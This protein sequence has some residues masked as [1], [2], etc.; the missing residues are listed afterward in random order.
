[1]SKKKNDKKVQKSKVPKPHK[2]K[3]VPDEPK[4]NV[5]SMS[6]A[7]RLDEGYH[8]FQDLPIMVFIGIIFAIVRMKT[9]TSPLQGFYWTN[10]K[11]A[12]SDFFSYYKAAFIILMATLAVL[13]LLYRLM[14]QSLII[15][16]TKL[17]IPMAIYIGFVVLSWIFSDYGHFAFKGYNDRFEGSI[18]IISYFIMMFYIINTVYTEKSVKRILTVLGVMT[19]IIGLLG[20]SQF[21]DMDFFRTSFGKKMITPR[22]YWPHV[23][24]LK[25][26]FKNREIYQTVYN[27]NYVSFYLAMIIPVFSMLFFYVKEMKY[28]IA[29]GVLNA[30]LII[31]LIGSKSSGG[32]L[33]IGVAFIVG[34]VLLNKRLL[35]W[36]KSVAV[37]LGVAIIMIAMTANVLLPELFGTVKRATAP[38]QAPSV[39]RTF[40]DYMDTYENKLDVSLNGQAVTFES[41][42]SMAVPSI[43]IY[44]TADKSIPSKRLEDG[45][46]II[47]QEG[48]ED[49][50]FRFAKNEDKF[51]LQLMVDEQPFNFLLA[52]EKM[53]YYNV[54]G[55]ETDLDRIDTFGFEGRAKFGSGRGY[56]WS[57]ALPVMFD[58]FIIGSGADTFIFEFPHND[59]YGKYNVDWRLNLVVDKPHSMYIQYGINTG[60]LSLFALIALFTS[61]CVWSIK[62][63][64]RR[65][66]SSFFDFAGSGIFLGVIGFLF[67]GIA[68][69]T[70]V[71]IMP[72]FYGLFALGITIN[73]FI[74]R[75]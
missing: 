60:M 32:L 34:I 19:F 36:W 64:Y 51:F 4:G 24:S 31:N 41:D 38:A 8:R 25:F 61:Y 58:H 30:L 66:Y 23:D 75:K 28:K 11:E 56:I 62:I 29:L 40:I 10:Y 48:Y 5:F 44:D 71:S 27:I 39:E 42:F 18:V 35:Q 46:F 6:H 72:M 17:Y 14:T 7:P 26:T 15:K 50:L 67:A 54:F 20:L 49:Y 43:T 53:I 68:N 33:G 55:N 59:Y 47:D 45:T 21:L 12:Y 57:R 9:Y 2:E 70:T 52:N 37:I 74:V 1:M 65:E 69:D 13:I 3:V 73:L 63:Y 16:K 22:Y